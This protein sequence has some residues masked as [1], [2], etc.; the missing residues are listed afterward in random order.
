MRILVIAAHPD[1]EVLG[2]GGTIA[3]M[4]AEG[5]EVHIQILGEGGTSRC[6][7]RLEADNAVV[8]DL[9]VCAAQAA[10][11]L[12]ASEVTV[13][14]L[15]DNRFDTVPLLDVVRLVETRL[16]E[17]LPDVV[18]T[19]HAGDLNIDHQITNRAVLTATRPC[20]AKCVREV[21]AFEVPS[22]TEWG[23][24]RL[25][26]VFRPN[27][28][29]DISSYVEAKMR[30]VA[31]YHTE[32]RCYPHPRSERGIRAQAERWGTVA[33]LQGA[34]AFELLRSIRADARIDSPRTTSGHR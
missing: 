4:A 17:L 7:D 22:S 34:E 1:D 27:V 2:C 13:H 21:L 11:E 26:P 3:R 30:A 10:A 5:E 15:P 31:A 14:D 33:G 20:A 8:Q 25:E 29:A 28:F 16:A 19:H 9:R 18:Y 12:G 23:F 32:M 6:P 24:Q